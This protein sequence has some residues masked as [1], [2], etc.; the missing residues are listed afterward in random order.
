MGVVDSVGY[1]HMFNKLIKL[2]RVGGDDGET[3][4]TAVDVDWRTRLRSQAL[5]DKVHPGDWARVGL[6]ARHHQKHPDYLQNLDRHHLGQEEV[7]T[8]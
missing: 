4:I 1:T 7:A 6:Q 8:L 5:G 2:L 3:S